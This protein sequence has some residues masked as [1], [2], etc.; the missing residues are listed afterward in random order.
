MIGRGGW[1][2]ASRISLLVIAGV[3]CG[4]SVGALLAP[5]AKAAP[6][7][8]TYTGSGD[9]GT[10]ANWS[11]GIPT[12][13]DV[14]QWGAGDTVTVSSGDAVQADSIKGGI[15]D[16][17]G[18]TLYLAS[19]TD[20]STLTS[21]TIS[22]G[23]L[24]GASGQTLKV[25]GDIDWASAPG[26]RA[27]LNNANGGQLAIVQT[28]SH[29]C[30]IGGSGQDVIYGGS[31]DAGSN[32]ITISA[33]DL[34]GPGSVTLSTSGTVSF[35]QASY[36]NDWLGVTIAAGGFVT[37]GAV[38][39]PVF[40]LHLTGS[41]GEIAGGTLTVAGLN[42]DPDSTL[43]IDP[44]AAL[45]TAGGTISGTVAGGALIESGP[46]TMTVD[47]TA[48]WSG[49]LAV[50]GG[51]VAVTGS[52]MIGGLTLSGG[53]ISGASGQTLAVAGD[54]DWNSA[55]GS[56]AS[57]NNA[58]G[59]QLAIVQ[60]GSHSCTIGGSG[61]DL[62]CNGSLDAGSNPIT[63][64]DSDFT[65][66]GASLS[67]ASTV[68]FTQPSYPSTLSGLTI[69]AD[70]FLTSGSL[71][72]PLY[73]LIQTGGA[74]KVPAGET[75]KAA[76]FTLQGG[77]LVVD[78]TIEQAN[79]ATTIG[80]GLLTGSGTI[81]A[82]LLNSGGTVA[83]GDSMPGCL[84]VAGHDYSQGSG[85][86]LE[87]AADG[88]T[89]QEYASLS[90]GGNVSLAGTLELVPNM[91]YQSAAQGGDTLA[92]LS[93]AG[94]LS[95]S[96]AGVWTS[97]GFSAGYPVSAT[98]GSGV[99]EA[100]LWGC[101]A[102]S[103]IGPQ[104]GPLT[105][106]TTV[107]ISGSGLSGASAVD[108][109][110]TPAA[111]YTVEGDSQIT[112][113]APSEAAGTVDVTVTTPGGTSAICAA[114][115]FAYLAAP[116][117][118]GISPPA[119][120]LAGGTTVTISGSGLSGAT[121]VKFG[122]VTA[123]FTVTS[124]T[125]ISATV[126]AATDTGSVDVTVTTPGGTSAICAA[127]QFAY[128]AAPTVT[129]ISPPAGPLAGGTTVTISG[130]GL[131]GATAVDFGTNPAPS[132]MVGSDT[133]I[134][135]AVPQGSAGVVDVTVTT[136]AGTSGAGSADCYTYR[137]APTVS[138]I[139]PASGPSAG[140]TSVT[141]SGTDLADASAVDFG[142][143]P[144]A[145]FTVESDTEITAV[146]PAGADGSVDVSVTTAGGTSTICTADEFT[147][148][149]SPAITVPPQ[150]S[151]IGC[152]GRTLTCTSGT[153]S[154]SPAPTYG[155]QWLRD[156]KAI[157]GATSASYVVAAADCGHVLACQ[158]TATNTAGYG[159]VTGNTLLVAKPTLSLKAAAAVVKL[160]HSVTLSG[161]L[162]NFASTKRTLRIYRR[163]GTRLIL[164][165][166]LTATS[167]GSYR[168]S[169]KARKAGK[170]TFVAVYKI[171]SL[172]VTSKAVT[173][174]LRS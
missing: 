119:G 10:A 39:A 157:G 174:T 17:S 36:Q 173:V 168:W 156:G 147:Y 142:T 32:P 161:A 145:S 83:P 11:A 104:T 153:W 125:E 81:D 111:S 140:D 33:S 112:A 117:V 114:D 91:G 27:S 106:G 61:C 8:D 55:T 3:L 73:A 70:G 65:A 87:I 105:G 6:P 58:N 71:S 158:V 144:A 133:Q 47:S 34:T 86:T 152:V 98:Y 19:A 88:S 100:V 31:L 9:W 155:Y 60:T 23:D 95:G 25:A 101:P 134:T 63:I 15:L 172:A 166:T 72:A 21:L 14:A 45:S 18:G 85:G 48:P 53:D 99:V 54:I 128:L 103:G 141:I 135:A 59:G 30:T 68:S 1:R 13:S 74:T 49:S 159:S 110:T 79:G 115:E 151:G 50:I 130:S 51:S 154:G 129:G 12:S 113:T 84:T 139:S 82:A 150:V 92:V 131:S 56:Q 37:S 4:L 170:W 5:Q 122:G 80:G 169:M 96:F 26:S 123:S 69:A 121:S 164:L 43:K 171:G 78:G 75:L 118:T 148:L 40:S 107:T 29:N 90:V 102:V 116:T 57:I 38:S 167:S 124:D 163:L 160:G 146:S 149:T 7:V 76:S 108:F 67:T 62:L 22:N 24:S 120:P 89:S 2:I 28:G 16:V 109:G 127:D 66:G 44:G 41:Q 93:C 20:Q 64:A 42:T 132:Y 137:A 126:P 136:S 138:G 162:G 94:G 97:P 35:T 77:T 165:K 46:Q 143:T 52:P